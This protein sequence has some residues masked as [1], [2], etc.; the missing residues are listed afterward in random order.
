MGNTKRTLVTL[1]LFALVA[2]LSS[3]AAQGSI[4]GTGMPPGVTVDH[5]V[6]LLG[7]DVFIDGT[8][9][10]DYFVLGNQVRVDGKIDGS[11]VLIGQ[12]ASIGGQL[13]TGIG[14]MQMYDGLM[15]LLVISVSLFGV[16]LLLAALVFSIGLGL[17]AVGLLPLAVLLWV[18]SFSLMVLALSLLWLLIV[19]ISK[20]IVSYPLVSWGGAALRLRW[21]AWLDVA[22]L[23]SGTFLYTLL[24]SLP[25]VGWVIAV[26]VVALGMG[27]VW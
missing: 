9:N 11:L 10:G 2:F 14:P 27:S 22:G 23:M 17:N 4:P 19:Y 13:R 25:Y 3:A 21:S 8:V 16:A 20:V 1:L 18:L 12:N 24:R 7:R 6:M 15:H 5:A 26:L